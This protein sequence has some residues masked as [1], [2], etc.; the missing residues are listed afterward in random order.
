MNDSDL[1]RDNKGIKLFNHCSIIL[2]TELKMPE[3]LL[4]NGPSW[5]N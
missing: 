2:H 5:H 4:E 3:G 1:P